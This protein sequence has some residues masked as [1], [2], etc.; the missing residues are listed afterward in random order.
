MF[1]PPVGGNGRRYTTTSFDIGLRGDEA[2]GE[3]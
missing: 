2:A 3:I 1:A